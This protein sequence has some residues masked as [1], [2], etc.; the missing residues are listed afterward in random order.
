MVVGQPFGPLG[1]RPLSSFSR[2]TFPLRSPRQSYDRSYSCTMSHIEALGQLLLPGDVA[3]NSAVR[4][5]SSHVEWTPERGEGA[6]ESHRSS[7][8]PKSREPVGVEHQ[9]SR[10]PVWNQLESQPG[11]PELGQTIGVPLLHCIHGP[12]GRERTKPLRD[13]KCLAVG[14]SRSPHPS[15]LDLVL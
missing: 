7:G 12:E 15:T 9:L 6:E 3:P 14:S 11:V 2:S 5:C 1:T 8:V 4:S 10:R 13:A